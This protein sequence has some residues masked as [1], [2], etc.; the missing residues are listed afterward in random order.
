MTLHS[1]EQTEKAGIFREPGVTS[2]CREPDD[3]VFGI[4]ENNISGHEKP[5]LARL[6]D[7]S[8]MRVV[9]E[10]SRRTSNKVG[11]TNSPGLTSRL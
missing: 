1:R 5:S 8:S 10:P 9:T 6:H 7:A 11:R 3:F 4:E 2:S